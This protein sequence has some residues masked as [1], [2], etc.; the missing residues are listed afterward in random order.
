MQIGKPVAEIN[1]PEALVKR[2]AEELGFSIKHIEFVL[3]A[4]FKI[5]EEL[6]L[7]GECVSFGGVIRAITKVA[8]IDLSELGSINDIAYLH[9][10]AYAETGFETKALARYCAISGNKIRGI[11]PDE[12]FRPTP[13]PDWSV[14]HGMECPGASAKVQTRQSVELGQAGYNGL[15]E[16]QGIK[17]TFRN[18]PR[19]GHGSMQF[20]NFLEPCFRPDPIETFRD[21]FNRAEGHQI[22][23]HSTISRACVRILRRKKS[24]MRVNT[25]RRT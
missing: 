12:S 10:I 14:L 15:H 8:W 6:L 11:K 24:N 13:A 7:G 18:T 2:V 17:R 23:C 1:K 9:I 25:D 16:R 19:M 20:S 4:Y 5:Q 21:H 22:R 3:A